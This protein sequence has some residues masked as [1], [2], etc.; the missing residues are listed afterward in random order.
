MTQEADSSSGEQAQEAPSMEAVGRVAAEVAHDLNNL[1]WIILGNS[2]MVAEE[3]DE[4]N[5]LRSMVAA[6]RDAAER[7]STLTQKLRAL[8]REQK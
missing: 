1:L 5:P 8:S 4:D 6:I 2:D 3:M 7:S